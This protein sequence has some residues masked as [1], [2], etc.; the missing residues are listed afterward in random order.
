[1]AAEFTWWLSR[2]SQAFA[3]T[4]RRFLPGNDEVL[5]IVDSPQYRIQ[6]EG[7]S[8]YEPGSSRIRSGATLYMAAILFTSRMQCPW[9][10][11]EVPVS[12]G[13]NLQSRRSW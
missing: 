10:S 11:A 2:C 3:E 4:L 5:R 6:D 7:Y 1:M 13:W 8:A 9:C 12:E